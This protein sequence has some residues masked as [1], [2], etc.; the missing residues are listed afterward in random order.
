MRHRVSWEHVHAQYRHVMP[1]RDPYARIP[2]VSVP[3]PPKLDTLRGMLRCAWDV[4]I[5]YRTAAMHLYG[6]LPGSC[7]DIVARS[8]IQGH[9]YEK[10]L[11]QAVDLLL[12]V[13]TSPMVWA[14]SQLEQSK[15][16]SKTAKMRNM[17]LPIN[18][19]FSAKSFTLTANV[20]RACDM[21][22][23]FSTAHKRYTNSGRQIVALRDRLRLEILSL[24]LT[25]QLDDA[26]VHRAVAST[27][28]RAEYETLL[29]KAY[30]EVD[31]AEY[32]IK[33]DIKRGVWVWA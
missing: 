32:D 10:V 27:L 30:D 5:G 24:A 1:S 25:D 4:L 13:D 6:R 19:I 15:Q 2:S 23:R 26:S 22:Q 8:D 11:T 21:E 31:T 7:S 20:L 17:I 29:R 9:K 14:Y 3:V 28:P 33:R 12:A 18:R 16:Y